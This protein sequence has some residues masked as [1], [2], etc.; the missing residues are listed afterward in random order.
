MQNLDVPHITA[1]PASR[2]RDLEAALGYVFVR[3]E[4]LDLALTHSSWANECGEGQT[5][6]ERLEFLGDAVLELCVSTKLYRRFP[7]AREG[8][9][10][11]MR[12]HLVSTVSL[13]ERARK[14][15]LDRLLKLG[16]G[17]ESQGGRTRDSVLSDAFE[18]V[19]AAVYA[20][21]GFDVAQRVVDRL[22]VDRWP[23]RA[24]KAMPKDYKTRLQEVSQQRFGQPPMYTRLGSHGPE[25]SKV[26]EIALRL[27][28][29]TEFTAS[30]SSCKK[31]EQ[32]AALQALEM[33]CRK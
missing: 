10:T 19:L 14:V 31:A 3:P 2:A 24:E 25:H 8:E 11:K 7:D 15:G 30:G 18:A 4:L 1:V 6:N 32:S 12:S 29:G 17:E 20:D 21:G 33:L 9:L 27:P 13:A 16:R 28:D 26:F 22:F 5:H 23:E